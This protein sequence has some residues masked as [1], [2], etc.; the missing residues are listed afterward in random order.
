MGAKYRAGETHP[1]D[2]TAPGR[3][4]GRHRGNPGPAKTAIRAAAGPHGRRM[5]IFKGEAPQVCVFT[6]K[7]CRE[8]KNPYICRTI[9]EKM[10][11]GIL[12]LIHHCTA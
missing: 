5:R 6:K 4:I 8:K 12:H 3:K 10:K 9:V 11:Y 2:R 1:G 7:I